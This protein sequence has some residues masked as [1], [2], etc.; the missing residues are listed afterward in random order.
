VQRARIPVPIKRYYSSY[1]RENIKLVPI[2]FISSK[3]IY[4]TFKIFGSYLLENTPHLGYKISRLMIR[5]TNAVCS[6]NPTKP[7]NR[8]ALWRMIFPVTE[9]YSWCIITTVL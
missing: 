3:L 2:T 9:Y 4:T 5:K 1:W 7:I 8:P 6:D